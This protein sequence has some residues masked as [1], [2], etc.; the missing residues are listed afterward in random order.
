M[1]RKEGGQPGS[2]GLGAFLRRLME[3]ETKAN[4]SL[5]IWR[6]LIVRP[7][8][9]LAF[10]LI[11][12]LAGCGGATSANPA[13][14]DPPGSYSTK[15]SLNESA[16]SEGGK[17]VNGEAVGIDWADVSTTPGL[18]DPR[19][20]DWLRWLPHSRPPGRLSKEMPV[21]GQVSLLRA[22]RLAGN[23]SLGFE[24]HQSSQGKIAQTSRSRL[25]GAT[26]RRTIDPGRGPTAETGC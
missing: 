9:K 14:A 2:A 12:S 22:S 24:L 6:P 26:F 25:A 21:S 17:W 5:R 7:V 8:R 1:R 15:F 4:S 16:I 18:A 19:R 10:L 20:R 23:Y 3:F 11:I 13:V